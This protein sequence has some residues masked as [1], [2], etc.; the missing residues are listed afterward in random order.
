MREATGAAAALPDWA[1]AQ[2]RRPAPGPLLLVQSFINTWNIDEHTDVLADVDAG[3]GWLRRAGMLGPHAP[4]Q[5]AELRLCR[6]V[7]ESIRELIARNGRAQDP[8]PD[9]LR[10]IETVLDRQD[11]QPADRLR[12]AI[13][14]AGHVTVASGIPGTLVSGLLGLLLLIRDA[15]RD[16]QWNRLKICGNADC[17]WAFYDRSHSRMG[18]WCEMASCGNMIKNRNFRARRRSSEGTNTALAARGAVYRERGRQARRSV[19]P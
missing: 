1:P 2:E 12:L 17:R 4:L 6:E 8:T 11:G 14:G 15:Q 5:P 16:G 19:G 18:A 7:R 13:D 10:P 9:D 3:A